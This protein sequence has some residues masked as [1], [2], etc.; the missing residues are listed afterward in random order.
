MPHCLPDDRLSNAG[1]VAVVILLFSG[2]EVLDLAGPYEVFA[3]ARNEFGKPHATVF[4]VAET[5]GG[6]VSRWLA[7]HCRHFLR[8]RPRREPSRSLSDFVVLPR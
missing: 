1:E 7:R 5:K 8:E 4:T 3:A 2:V 6:P